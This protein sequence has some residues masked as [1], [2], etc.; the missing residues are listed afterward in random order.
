[1]MSIGDSFLVRRADSARRKLIDARYADEY[2]RE[3][4]HMRN[5]RR[6]P[7]LNRAILPANLRAK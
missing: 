1:M 2:L 4:I 7:G 3:H 5:R 6:F